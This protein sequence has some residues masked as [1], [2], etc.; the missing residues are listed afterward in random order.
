MNTTLDIEQELTQFERAGVGFDPLRA[1]G[2]IEL[3]RR[4][5]H[6]IDL[7]DAF[8]AAETNSD[9]LPRLRSAVTS[10]ATRWLQL[11][12]PGEVRDRVV[13]R[14]TALKVPELNDRLVELM[15][16]NTAGTL[17]PEERAEFE[18]LHDRLDFFQDALSAALH[19]LPPDGS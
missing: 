8:Q 10:L 5:R 7:F 12:S 4:W 3:I 1:D 6:G 18:R 9:E 16:K 13:E 14:M 2:R 17:T 15:P 11:R 19:A